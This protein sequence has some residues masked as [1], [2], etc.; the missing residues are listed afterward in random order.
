MNHASI[1]REDHLQRCVLVAEVI[2]TL[3]A[4][5]T[6]DWCD[7]AARMLASLREDCIASLSIGLFSPA[8]D[9]LQLEATGVA[10]ADRSDPPG[11]YLHTE[12]TR[13]MGWW[14]SGD[15]PVL[16]GVLPPGTDTARTWAASA[17]GRRWRELGVDQLAI[18]IGKLTNGSMTSDDHRCVV[19]ELGVNGLRSEPL[20]DA[21]SGALAA[22]A[23]PLARR[24]V[25][26]FG[27][28]P[29]DPINRITPREQVILEQLALGRTVKQIAELLNRSPHTVHDHVKSLHRKLGA[30]S[31]GELIARALGH[32]DQGRAAYT[33]R[34]SGF[35]GLVNRPNMQ[36]AAV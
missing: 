5:A 31:R 30:T 17:S 28:E 6:Q 12:S 27:T 26:A 22:V 15:Q 7:R 19:L 3:P 25:L 4:V 35:R 1:F 2:A 9:L 29:S 18:S 36:L 32:I 8:G 24:A 11:R 21:D 13:S 16:S 10:W 34:P 23:S 20:G 33:V 14:L